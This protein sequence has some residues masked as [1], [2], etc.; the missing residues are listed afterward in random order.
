MTK[1]KFIDNL[2]NNALLNA[3]LIKSSANT[4]LIRLSVYKLGLVVGHQM[5]VTK[6]LI[7]YRMRKR[8]W[9]LTE[10]AVIMLSLSGIDGML[11][12]VAGAD[13]KSGNM[14]KI[15]DKTAQRQILKRFVQITLGR[16]A[17]I[18]LD[19]SKDQQL[20]LDALPILL[21]TNHPKFPCFVSDNTPSGIC[22]Y[23]PSGAEI[24]KLQRLSPGF[25]HIDQENKEQILGVFLSGDCGTIIESEQQNIMVWGGP[26]A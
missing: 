4:S 10:Q 5:L 12:M 16:L 1:G 8:A 20:F 24:Q 2:T 22:R 3:I 19:L 23:H 18:R 21:H 13:K 14:A 11:T 25:T 15:P 26:E 7:I 17:R 9:L 6:Y